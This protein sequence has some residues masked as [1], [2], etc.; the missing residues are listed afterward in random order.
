MCENKS[1]GMVSAEKVWFSKEE[2]LQTGLY[3]ANK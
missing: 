2:I 1:F 3:A